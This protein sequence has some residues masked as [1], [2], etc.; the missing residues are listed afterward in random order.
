MGENYDPYDEIRKRIEA[1]YKRRQSSFSSLA[2]II[3]FL[4]IPWGLWLSTDPQARMSVI[5]LAIITALMSI[6][7]VEEIVKLVM[8]ELKDRAVDRAIERE[9]SFELMLHGY[10]KPKRDL[11]MRLS[12]EG[13]LLDE[14]A[15]IEEDHQEQSEH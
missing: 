11:Q 8:G 7:L 1:R 10:E 2:V 3:V 15:I 6:P 9:R 14:P 5:P 12:D 13:E 4:A